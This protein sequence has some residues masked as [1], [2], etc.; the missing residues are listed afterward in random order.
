MVFLPG[1][2][3]FDVQANITS[4]TGFSMIQESEGKSS[5]ICSGSGCG[6]F[7]FEN[8]SQ[9]DITN[10]T[11]I[12]DS[13]SITVAHVF[14]VRFVN[15]TFANS[16]NTAVVANESGLLLEGNVFTNNSGGGVD[17]TAF[18]PGG[19]ISVIFSNITLRG[20]NIF[21]NNT[22]ISNTTLCGGGAMYAENSTV[23]LEGNSSFVNNTVMVTKGDQFPLISGG[24]GLFLLR[25]TV[26]ITGDVHFTNNRVSNAVSAPN[27]CTCGG[28][29]ALVLHSDAS[30]SGN[31]TFSSNVAVGESGC[32]GG[33]YVYDSSVNVTESVVLVDNHAGFVGGGIMTF[34]S[35]LSVSGSLLLA[36]NSGGQGGGLTIQQD[37]NMD[38]TGTLLL[39]N[40]SAGSL[41]GGMFV[42]GSSMNVT[43]SAVLIDN[44]A[45]LSGG[46][47]QSLTARINIAGTVSISKSSAGQYGGGVAMATSNL[48]VS[49]NLL[50]TGNSGDQGGGL[51]IQQDSNMDITGTVVLARNS[52]DS[53][54]GGII[55]ITSN[56]SINGSCLLTDNTAGT[57][58]GL[59]IQHDSSM[60]ITGTMQLTNN[61]A[62]QFGG[63]IGMSNANMSVSGS[64][65]LTD[66]SGGQGGGLNIQNSNMDITGTMVLTNN[67][68]DAGGGML[69]GSCGMTASGSVSFINNSAST[70]G[71]G[72]FVGS[73]YVTLGNTLFT[74]DNADTQDGGTTVSASVLFTNNSAGNAGG[75]VAASLSNITLS[76][77]CFMGNRANQ[78]GGMD[79]QEGNLFI[80]GRVSF[81]NNSA[82][83]IGGG[84]TIDVGS[85][86]L[87]GNVS[88]TGNHAIVQGGGIG[89]ESSNMSLTGSVVL[90]GN[91]AVQG[92]GI[93]VGRSSVHIPGTVLLTN[94]SAHEGGGIDLD[95]GKLNISG[96]IVLTSNHADADGGGMTIDYDSQ[97]ALTGN[98]Y[99][100]E[101]SAVSGGA[102]YFTDVSPLLYCASV[103]GAECVI[104]DCFFQVDTNT[105]HSID[106]LLV[107]ED[108][109]A[110]MGSVLFGGSV[111]R[112]T[113]ESDPGANSGEVFDRIANYS[114]QLDTLSAI[115]SEAFRVC[116]C[117]DHQVCTAG[118]IIRTYPGKT[119]SVRVAAVGQRNGTHPAAVNA[120]T[121]PSKMS[122]LNAFE[123][124]QVVNNSCTELNYT[125]FSNESLQ[126]E[127][128][129]DGSCSSLDGLN[130]HLYIPVHLLHCPHAFELSES[131][132][133]CICEER[134]RKYTNSC[135]I[136]DQTI[137][138]DGDFWVGYDNDNQSSGLIL[139]PHCPF[140]YC[141][142]K[143]I[144]FTLN[145]TD[146]QC[147]GDRS[148]LLCGACR[149]NHSLALG[150]SRCL[151]CSDA[152]LSLLVPF[153]VMGVVLV[154]FLL[155]C[156]LTVALG[157][158]SGLVFYANI[159]QANRN[160]F[161]P[162]GS[163]NPLT[164]FI[165]WVNLD[166]GI[167]TCFY[168]G[169]DAFA[170]TW[171]QF[172]FPIYIWGV[173]GI[174]MFIS[175]QSFTISRMLGKNPV[176]VLA[177]LFLL[178][179]AKILRNIITALS[180]AT[181]Q[182]PNE[183]QVVWLNDA[184]I[185][186]LEGKHIPLF[187]VGLLVFVLLFLPYTLLLL[188]GQWLL[189]W[190]NLKILFWMNNTKLKAFFDSYH[191]PYKE[192]HRYWTGLLL[193]VR[194]A[195]LLVFGTNVFGE[196]S[197]NL[198][199]ISAASFGLLAWPWL[200]G[201]VYK[202][203]YL[204]VLEA[205]FILNL[206]ISAVATSYVQQAGGNQAVVSYISTGIAFATFIAILL[207]HID[208]QIK[209]SQFL[210]AFCRRR[211]DQPQ[212]NEREREI[213]VPD[214]GG[215]ALDAPARLNYGS[216]EFR[217]PLLADAQ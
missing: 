187:V 112:C 164:V 33:M 80:T 27:D 5:I 207:Y 90:A 190:S 98:V 71:G 28:G 197:E 169:M 128:Y 124:R 53:L 43:D 30:I 15:C 158:L 81:I 14:E 153:A 133:G 148:G 40:N 13:Q 88:F 165:A 102:I 184:N 38:I 4:I 54:G 167:E 35:N 84:M 92:G 101:N 95:N 212:G 42:D 78:G 166:L 66:N 114:K 202:N 79:F 134:L 83:G 172:A 31:V 22:C 87:A 39:T 127:L 76:N 86:T 19:G 48:S 46:G 123:D 56:M 103:A 9:L 117:E 185:R 60:D 72:A 129:V 160:V 217:E 144:R 18:K 26:D 64:L 191:S 89:L 177:T 51:N 1:D 73:S 188:F 198:L 115:T 3:I 2:H 91:H 99:F 59:N 154:F 7:Y 139:H 24:G 180:L 183:S 136:N 156:R 23:N 193:V 194:F 147:K 118:N 45:G 34:D 107:F 200:I 65:L 77:A 146:R 182:Y 130:N 171:L 97:M 138:R 113:L 199:A 216:G 41:G 94:N 131:T 25:T 176:E 142:A 47:I 195:L 173:I 122:R 62:R 110:E 11:F 55:M 159:V 152:Y 155:A 206:G 120:I 61:S 93:D 174:I 49:G 179:Y 67:S 157:T 181:L 126:L 6:G 163:S 137:E 29:G 150:S 209:V 111:D 145:H 215:R 186:Y 52:A 69:V 143:S 210:K 175:S 68:A 119:I 204:G 50:L 203:W 132:Q 8:V 32:G 20:Q 109:K 44:H 106:N 125:T 12:S 16:S 74:A 192:K 104:E 170:K 57:G 108:N 63:G 37:S 201:T 21:Q 178:S 75:G 100:I 196:E 162:P 70:N 214:A 121:S 140:D 82:G 58:G 105:S 85:A 17:W 10:L 151:S 96:S 168:D 208:L 205:S 189:A 211:G 213:L 149:S 36:D 116:L 135:D 161:F 141:K